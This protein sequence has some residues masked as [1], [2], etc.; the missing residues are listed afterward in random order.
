MSSDIL[1]RRVFRKGAVILREGETGDLAFLIQS[2]SVEIFT[3]KSGKDIILAHLKTGDIFGEMALVTDE[4]RA[5]SVRAAEETSVVLI[6][7]GLFRQKLEKTDTTI[8]AIVN[9]LVQRIIVANNT[10]YEKK[11]GYN[12]LVNGVRQA[13]D[14]IAKDLALS[15]Q[16]EFEI[17]VKPKLEQFLLAL[18]PFAEPP[19]G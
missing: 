15:K 13:Y 18:A 7:R 12:D 5:A 16:A 3:Q 4:P 9:M 19:K 14:G 1:E 2:G 10:I 17:T 6:E 11:S 8:R